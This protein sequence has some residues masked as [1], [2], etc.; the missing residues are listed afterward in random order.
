MYCSQNYNTP[1]GQKPT[2]YYTRYSTISSTMKEW[3]Y[4]TQNESSDYT[5]KI[6]KI[7]LAKN[8]EIVLKYPLPI[9]HGIS[10]VPNGTIASGILIK[11]KCN[12]VPTPLL[13][14]TSYSTILD[15]FYIPVYLT[16]YT[17]IIPSN[18]IIYTP[19][20]ISTN[21]SKLIVG[22]INFYLP[23]FSIDG[24]IPV[25]SDIIIYTPNLINSDY[26]YFSQIG[27]QNIYQKLFIV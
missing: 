25:A 26:S 5:K 2:C 17:P 16:S 14:Y 3:D 7:V 12:I 15:T 9:L 4:P 23:I 20:L 24:S 8:K 10:Y 6:K 11:N 13:F 19:T 22:N 21:Y 1:N 27:T 18:K